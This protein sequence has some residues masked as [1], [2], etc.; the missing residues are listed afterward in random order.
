MKLNR[1]NSGLAIEKSDLVRA[2]RKVPDR[3]KNKGIG[4]DEE[5][6]DK[7]RYF[8]RYF[9]DALESSKISRETE[10]SP[11][12]YAF[13][14][15]ATLETLIPHEDSGEQ[16]VYSGDLEKLYQAFN[17]LT[18][19]LADYALGKKHNGEVFSQM[20]NEYFSKLPDFYSAHEYRSKLA[21]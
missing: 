17:L 2:L 10:I 3:L 12:T 9:A 15:N 6:Q 4:I 13:L 1:E 18:E 21:A 14:Y 11:E 5:F 20:A 8:V 16:K 19:T 7:I